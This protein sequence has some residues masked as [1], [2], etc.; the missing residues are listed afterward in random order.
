VNGWEAGLSWN[1]QVE[2]FD[3]ASSMGGL[4]M[5]RLLILVLPQRGF[6]NPGE[7]SQNINSAKFTWFKLDARREKLDKSLQGKK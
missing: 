3:T 6:Q 7:M 1:F 5:L 2:C 4:K